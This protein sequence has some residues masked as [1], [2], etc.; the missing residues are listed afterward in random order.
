LTFG[1]AKRNL[2]NA[3]YHDIVLIK[4]DG[5]LGYPEMLPYDRVCITA[6]CLEVP[7]PLIEQLTIG[8]KLIT[9]KIEKGIQNLI[10]LEKGKKGVRRRVICEVLYVL[11]KGKYGAKEGRNG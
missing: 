4:G 5:G 9:P 11:L 1:F 7:L 8:G 10:L 3:G 6:A 2:E